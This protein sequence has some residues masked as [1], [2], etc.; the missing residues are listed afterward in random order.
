MISH[1]RRSLQRLL[2]YWSILVTW[3]PMV[4][5]PCT[6]KLAPRWQLS[7]TDWWRWRRRNVKRA[8][9]CSVKDVQGP[10]WG[11]FWRTKARWLKVFGSR[12][13]TNPV[14]SSQH[15]AFGE[16]QLYYNP[17]CWLPRGCVDVYRDRY[18]QQDVREYT[19][20]W[21][22]SNPFNRR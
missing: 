11:K 10:G 12:K 3:L 8:F 13:R 19:A 18:W 17:W 22:Q 5:V 1:E 20:L 21:K 4:E 6:E 2:P 16:D 9:V 15:S 7:S 14:R